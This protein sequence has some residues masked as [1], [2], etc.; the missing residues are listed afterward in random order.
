MG[1]SCSQFESRLQPFKTW[2]RKVFLAVRLC[3]GVIFWG[4]CS[5]CAEKGKETGNVDGD[6]G[7]GKCDGQSDGRFRHKGVVRHITYSNGACG[8]QT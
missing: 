6:K 3:P 5:L 1:F 4:G 8:A 2:E 7:N